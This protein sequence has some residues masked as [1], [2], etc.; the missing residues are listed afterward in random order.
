LLAFNIGNEVIN[1]PVN[2][3]A[4]RE[5]DFLP[6]AVLAHNERGFRRWSMFGLLLDVVAFVKAAARDTK[7][8]LKAKNIN[9]LVGYSSVDGEPAFRG[10]STRILWVI[11]SKQY[12]PDW[13]GWS[14]PIVSPHR[15]FGQ[16]LDLWGRDHLARSI[17][18]EWVVI[19]DTAYRLFQ[20]SLTNHDH[21]LID[22]YEWCGNSTFATSG[23]ESIVDDF[24]NLPVAAYMSEY[25]WAFSGFASGRRLSEY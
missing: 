2:T 19:Q 18:T 13:R 4:G 3:D 1:L 24:S 7:A 15:S 23:W 11:C 16:L 6:I 10:M 22:N 25:G 20:V 5:P 14:K 8:Y 21:L 9:A 12:E 17:R